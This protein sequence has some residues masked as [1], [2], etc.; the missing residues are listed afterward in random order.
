[1]AGRGGA[2]PDGYAIGLGDIV[3]AGLSAVGIT[4]ER[5]Q[6]VASAVGVKDCGCRGRQRRLNEIGREWLGI[7]LDAPATL[8]GERNAPDATQAATTEGRDEA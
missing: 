4:K 7:G 1:M 6:A 8:T 2:V 5:A 3:A